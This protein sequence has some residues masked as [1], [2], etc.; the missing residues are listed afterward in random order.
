[1]AFRTIADDILIEGEHTRSFL[2][3]EAILKGQ[4][5]EPGT[6]N[7]NAVEPS[8][9]DGA[10]VVGIALHDAAA[11]SMVNVALDGC[12]VR[13]TSGTGSVSGGDWVSSYGATGEEG[14]VQTAT[15]TV[16]TGSTPVDGDYV[17]GWA[18]DDDSGTNDD[19]P[20]IISIGRV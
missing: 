14:E 8:D 19:V 9:A 10:M 18:T 6:T 5:L 3:E 7:D 15:A 2:A 13:A 12:K 17:L 4:V 11:G 20:V 1:M 16:A